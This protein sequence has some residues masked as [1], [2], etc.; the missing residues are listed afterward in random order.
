MAR[1]KDLYCGLEPLHLLGVNNTDKIRLTLMRQE[2]ILNGGSERTAKPPC[3]LDDLFFIYCVPLGCS[4]TLCDHIINYQLSA[5]SYQ[6]IPHN[7][8]E[9]SS[10]QSAPT[11]E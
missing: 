6:T 4:Y 9:I 7:R 8:Q 5:T 3:D 1:C 2:K 10:T 11:F